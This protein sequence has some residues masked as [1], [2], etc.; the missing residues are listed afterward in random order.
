MKKSII[1]LAVA[2]ALAAPAVSMADATLYGRLHFQMNFDKNKDV[3][4]RNA[5]HRLGVKGESEMDSGLTAFYQLETEYQNDRSGQTS[6]SSTVDAALKVRQANAGV[7]GEFGKVTVGRFTNPLTDTYVADVVERNSG[8][9]EQSPFRVGNAIS[10]TTPDLSGFNGYAAIIADGLGDDDTNKDADAYVVGVNYKAN[11]LYA[12]L[13]YM[14]SNYKD[15]ADS[16]ST[17]GTNTLDI[18]KSQDL[19]L[20]LS[21]TINNFYVGY[22]YEQKK[23][24]ATVTTPTAVSDGDIKVK[25][26]DFMATYAMDKTT[27]ALGYAQAK[28]SDTDFKANRTLVGVYQNL[29]GGA[30]V[31]VEYAA[32]NGDAEDG[33]TTTTGFE[34][35]G[36][37]ADNVTLG[38]RVKF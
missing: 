9:Y 3:D 20:G 34:A 28:V 27:F 38:Y 10:Y 8:V 26:H 7:K 19:S 36:S 18:N 1:A 33:A 35:V 30:D 37:N 24:D 12:G 4:I 23:Y 25:V 22:N 31:Y 2:G 5:G 29:G 16:S 11:G 15:G 14:A 13:G 32:Y 17:D 6:D 21:Y